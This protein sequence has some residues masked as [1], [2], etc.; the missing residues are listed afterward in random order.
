MH[1]IIDHWEKKKLWFM[2]NVS[3]K[4]VRFRED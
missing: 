4:S 1:V 3:P 2:V